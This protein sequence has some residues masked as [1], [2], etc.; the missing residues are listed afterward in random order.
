MVLNNF[1]Y[2]TERPL[3]DGPFN[4][5]QA[6]QYSLI[7]DVVGGGRGVVV[8]TEDELENALKAA[9]TYTEGFTIIDVQLDP[10]DSSPAL[11]RLTEGLAKNI[12]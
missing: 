9:E 12:R 3:Q 7:P 4:D 1:G 5:L 2:A 8:T 10:N 11:Q 6:W